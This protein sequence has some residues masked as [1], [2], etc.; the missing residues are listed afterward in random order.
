MISILPSDY[1]AVV[2]MFLMMYMNA[3]I[4]GGGG[5]SKMMNFGKSRAKMSR[6]NIEFYEGCWS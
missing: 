4:G 1:H 6:T 5:N 2:I 3:R